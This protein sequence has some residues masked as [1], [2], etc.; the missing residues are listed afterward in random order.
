MPDPRVNEPAALTEMR[1]AFARYEKALTT[2]D[3]ATLDELFH[4]SPHTIRLGAGEELFGY[5]EIAEF[6]RRRPAAGLNRDEVRSEVTVFDDRFAV[7]SLVFTRDNV[8]GVGR[9]T[10]TWVR[11]AEGWRVVAAHVSQRG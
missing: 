10:Q 11:F 3:I 8:A 2:N 7:T 9:Q 6:R 5:P 4:D 1:E